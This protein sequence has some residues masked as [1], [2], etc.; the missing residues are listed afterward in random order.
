MADDAWDQVGINVR[1]LTSIVAAAED[2]DS[3]S[4]LLRT[5]KGASDPTAVEVWLFSEEAEGMVGMISV[6]PTGEVTELDE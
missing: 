3:D 2:A 6:D 1:Q 5:V 4:V